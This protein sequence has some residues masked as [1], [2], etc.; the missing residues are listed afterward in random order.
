MTIWDKIYKDYLK[1]GP[2]WA[3]IEGKLLPLFVD[4]VENNKFTVRHALEIGCGMGKYL[5]FLQELG[6]RVDGIDSSSTAIKMTKNNLKSG[7]CIIK[8]DMFKYKIPRKKYDLIFSIAT[9]HHGLKPIVKKVIDEIYTALVLGGKVFITLPDIKSNRKWKTFLDHK[10]LGNGTFAPVLGP[11]KG[12]PHSFYTKPEV[13][14]LFENFKK[15]K[16]VLDDH[17]KIVHGHWIISGEK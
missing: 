9:V 3:T 11:E 8:A 16:I 12:L 14:E 2:A 6:F 4:F 10:D 1:G 15:V 5:V 17:G 7:S 13:K